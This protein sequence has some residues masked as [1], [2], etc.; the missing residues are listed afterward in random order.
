MNGPLRVRASLHFSIPISSDSVVPS[1]RQPNSNADQKWHLKSILSPELLHLL[2]LPRRKLI[3]KTAIFFAI[4]MRP[5]C[6]EQ[7][8]VNWFLY[9]AI[10][11][12]TLLTAGSQYAA[13]IQYSSVQ[14]VLWNEMP[15]LAEALVTHIILLYCP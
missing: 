4:L 5:G 13:L 1:L 14:M 11:P 3:L 2:P 7:N 8:Q 9:G 6:N 12:N 10:D 15:G